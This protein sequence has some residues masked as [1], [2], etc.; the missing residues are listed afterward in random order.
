MEEKVGTGL[1]LLYE[2]T[3]ITALPLL[4]GV[5]GLAASVKCVKLKSRLITWVWTLSLEFR[6]RRGKDEP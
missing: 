5:L 4:C 3:S 2:V 6:R 1:A